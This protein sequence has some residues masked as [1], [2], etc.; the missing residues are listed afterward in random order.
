MTAIILLAFSVRSTIAQNLNDTLDLPVFE[1]KSEFI[2][3]N[4]GFKRVRLDSSILIPK[5][6]GD[7]GQILSQHSTIFIKS[8]GNGTLAT[9]S[10]RGT[11]A[12]HTQVQWNGISLNSPMLGQTDMS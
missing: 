6:G 1:L 3:N 9:S 8:Y 7:L 2:L 12:Q 4:Q 10:F 5:S 11:A